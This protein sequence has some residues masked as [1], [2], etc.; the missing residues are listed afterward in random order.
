MTDTTVRRPRARPPQLRR[1]ATFSVAVVLALITAAPIL[2]MVSG[3]FKDEADIFDGSVLPSNP[4]WAN[5]RYV[6]ESVPF[7]NYLLNSF[8]VATIV[9]V[10]SLL[11][12]SM[13]A[14]ALARLRFPGRDMLFFGFFSTILVSMPMIIVP[15]FVLV[16]EL[17]LLNSYP[18][19][20]APMIF[21]AFAL[22]LLRQFYLTLPDELE[23]QAKIDG[24][25]PLRIYR[26]IA[27]P[28]SR[29]IMAALAI[30]V[31]LGAWNAFLWPLTTTSDEGLWVVQV[32]IASLQGEFSGA[33]NYILAASTIASIPTIALFLIF[34]RQIIE[35]IKTA[36]LK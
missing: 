25:G 36:G 18:G 9:T 33:W 24:C 32:G 34:Q 19:I 7:A 14:Y 11:A 27:L 5:F 3:A 20:A 2:L 15:L 17:G 21:Q 35:S 23:E 16:R 31:F 8:I 22:F 4:T 10:A 30:F 12:H 26:S 1:W 29:P 28:L 6:L 13:A